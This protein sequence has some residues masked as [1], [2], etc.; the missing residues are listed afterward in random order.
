MQRKRVKIFESVIGV[1]VYVKL[2]HGNLGDSLLRNYTH[3]KVRIFYYK[4]FKREHF[5]CVFY[6]NDVDE[7]LGPERNLQDHC[8]LLSLLPNKVR[9]KREKYLS[10]RSMFCLPLIY[11]IYY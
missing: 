5:K 6:I 8:I 9:P 10:G 11:L 2:C 7:R 4:L 3:P 1:K